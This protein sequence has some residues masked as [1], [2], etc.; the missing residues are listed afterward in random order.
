MLLCQSAN[1][2]IF[3]AFR[4]SDG[5]TNWQ[6]IANFSGNA[7]IVALTV[8]AIRLYLSRRQARRYSHELEEIRTQLELRVKNARRP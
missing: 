3:W 1:A 4:E 5:S 7:L 6:Y 8:T 2:D